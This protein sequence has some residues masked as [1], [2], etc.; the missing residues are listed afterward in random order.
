MI[1]SSNIWVVT[2]I[3]G[4][5]MDHSYDYTPAKE[6]IQWLQKLRIPVIPCTSKTASEVKVI[7]NEL[8][9][10]DPYIVENGGAIYGLSSD[11]QP[12]ELVLGK[13]YE[14]LENILN[15]ISEE[16][17]FDLKPLKKLADEEAFQL[18]S[19]TGHSLTLMSDRHWSMP[20]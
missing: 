20:F 11:N 7:R 18:T 2:D 15:L 5:L 16:V 4:T 8:N 13:S 19:L 6:T 17:E 14:A 12:R 10:K 3:D 9:L 1:Y